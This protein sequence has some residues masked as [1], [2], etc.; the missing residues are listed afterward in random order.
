MAMVLVGMVLAAG[1]SVKADGAK[2]CYATV[3]RVEGIVSYS[4]GDNNWYPLVPGK[5]L[6]PGSVVRTGENGTVD[7]VLEQIPQQTHSSFKPGHVTISQIG[8]ASGLVSYKPSVEQNVVRLIPGTVLSIDKFTTLETGVDKVTDTELNLKKGKIY[9]SV[10]KPS[11]AS[12]FLVKIPTGIVGVRGTL[13]VIG[14]DGGVFVFDPNQ[15]SGFTG[16]RGGAVIANGNNVGTVSPGAKND[17]GKDDV[18]ISLILP[19]GT[20]QTT[21]LSYGQAIDVSTGTVTSIAS[22]P[23]S[24]VTPLL[25]AFPSL[26]TV[27]SAQQSAESNHTQQNNVSDNG[28]QQS[29]PP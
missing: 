19:N 4:L 23:T 24:V 11:A 3:V 7:V 16:V 27:Y 5:Y 1:L 8:S 22:L 29:P 13:V 18:V 17:A 14:A 15:G 21:T 28:G 20:T 12:Q 9:A 2:S 25:Q 10:K 26:Q 6:P